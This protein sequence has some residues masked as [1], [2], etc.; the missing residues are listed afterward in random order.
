MPE[1]DTIFRTAATLRKWIGGRVISDATSAVSGVD[2]TLLIGR[3]ASRV[4]PLGK[5]VLMQ[6]DHEGNEP[7]LLR[8]HMMMTGSWHVYPLGGA[9]QRPKRQARLILVA[10]DRIAVCFNAPVVELTSETIDTAAGVSHLGPDILAAEFDVDAA[11][12]RARRQPADRPLGEL[13][14]DQRVVAGIGNIYRCESLF[15]QGHHPWTPTG[16]L[17]TEVL[18]ELLLR[19]EGLMR[20][21]LVA[22]RVAR[23]LDGGPNLTW[24]YRRA[25]KPCRRCGSLVES[26]PQGPQARTAYWCG[27]CQPQR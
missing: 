14:L 22:S 24:V 6:F 23:D 4:E 21:N 5:H 15:L 3:L 7:L 18:T 10:S 8:T 11:V 17:S 2:A 12:N 25:G 13:L 20:Q 9:W 27:T 19:A 1:G 16:S 26:R